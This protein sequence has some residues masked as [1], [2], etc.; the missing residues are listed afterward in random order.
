MRETLAEWRATLAATDQVDLNPAVFAHQIT[1]MLEA[2]FDETLE[3]EKTANNSRALIG[4][5]RDRVRELEIRGV[6]ERNKLHDLFKTQ[7]ARGG[8]V[9]E[10]VGRHVEILEQRYDALSVRIEACEQLK[11]RVTDL[12]QVSD[13]HYIALSAHHTVLG[14]AAKALV[15]AIHN[16]MSPRN[17][18]LYNM[19]K[20]LAELEAILEKGKPR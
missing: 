9:V 1:E 19:A 18:E 12:E 20:P 10:E 3:L 13:A 14:V 17:L 5:N 2:L 6:E 15:M 11:G 7:V 8:K 4:N 16:I